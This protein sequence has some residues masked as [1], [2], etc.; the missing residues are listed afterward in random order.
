[1][2]QRCCTDWQPSSSARSGSSSE[3]A[4]APSSRRNSSPG[5][6]SLGIG[7]LGVALA[8]GLTVLTGVYA[9][10]TIS[11][12]HF[13]PAGTL[14][15]ALVAPRRVESVAGELDYSGHRRTGSRRRCIYMI[16]SGQEGW[17][18]TGNMAAMVSATTRRAATDGVVLIAEV[19]LTGRLHARH[20]LRHRRPGAK[21]LLGLVDRADPDADRPDLDSHLEHVGQPGGSTAVAFFNGDGA[22]TNLWLFWSAPLA[23]AAIAGIAYPFLFGNHEEF[24]DRP[25]RDDALEGARLIVARA[26]SG[27][28]PPRGVRALSRLYLTGGFLLRPAGRRPSRSSRPRWRVVRRSSPG[29]LGRTT[30]TSRVRPPGR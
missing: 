15:A 18:A 17:T 1:M 26:E 13:N 7:F 25:V 16:A 12:G 27:P 11:G 14:G 20:P 21:R 23:G 8:F 24:G 30:G 5:T 28:H 29:A 4:A 19:V 2:N 3:A 6:R 10:G 9:F 22:P